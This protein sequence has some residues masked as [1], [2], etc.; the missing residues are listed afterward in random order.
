MAA[1]QSGNVFVAGDDGCIS[2][3]S[4][5]GATWTRI[6]HPDVGSYM[7]IAASTVEIAPAILQGQ[8]VVAGYTP[9]GQWI[10]RRSVDAG[11]TWETVDV[12][13]SLGMQNI[14]GAAIDTAGNMYVI[15]YW[16]KTTTVKN[17]TST[18]SY[19]RIRKIAKDAIAGSELGKTT[20]DLEGGTP[21]GIT[22]VGTNVF[23]A[24]MS[25]DRWQVRKLGSGQTQWILV[26]DFRYNEN[27]SS[28]AWS[29]AADGAGN[30]YVVGK[31]LTGTGRV[32]ATHWIVRKG[33]GA[34]VTAPFGGISFQTVDDQSSAANGVAP[35][36]VCADPFGNVYVTGK[37][38]N[39]ITRRH[40]ATSAP[41]DWVT[42]D[43]GGGQIGW[44]VVSDSSGN[45]FSA[46]WTTDSDWVIRRLLAP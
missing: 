42:S 20:F 19:S 2:R 9:T 16:G 44:D 5:Q 35:Y 22:C 13:P 14:R 21:R 31:G 38:G 39:W 43:S 46:G 33:S 29:I 25:G 41:T 23:V 10:T 36:G 8:V 45:V 40:S 17:K 1:D 6:L 15:G 11:E 18:T 26:D 12:I 28:E 3:T 34:G 27:Y 7:G 32:T 24:G 37:G 30:L 4:D